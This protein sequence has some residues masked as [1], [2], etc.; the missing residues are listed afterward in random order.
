[1]AVNGVEHGPGQ[2]VRRRQ[3]AKLSQRRSAGR[4]L[5][6]QI[7]ANKPPK[8][9]ALADHIFHAILSKKKIL[10]SPDIQ[11]IL[12]ALV[13]TGCHPLS[14]KEQYFAWSDFV[15]ECQTRGHRTL[16]GA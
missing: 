13:R 14:I 9:L 8:R 10:T 3:T 7:N 2:M 11:P 6:I 1:V 12:Y 16:A 15:R 4:C 5:D